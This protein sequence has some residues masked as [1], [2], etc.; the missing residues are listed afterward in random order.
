[1]L[2]DGP[3]RR[4]HSE[5]LGTIALVVAVVS[6]WTA[7][8][9]LFKQNSNAMPYYTYQ[10]LQFRV[11]FQALFFVLAVV[12]SKCL[13]GQPANVTGSAYPKWRLVL[14]GL[15][16][17]AEGY[18]QLVGTTHTNGSLMILMFQLVIPLT[19]LG[20]VV[21]LKRSFTWLQYFSAAVI[22]GGVVLSL[23]SSISVNPQYLAWNF[24]F[25]CSTF[26]A[27]ASGLLKERIFTSK[28]ADVTVLLAYTSS[29]QFLGGWVMGL[30][31]LFLP[32]WGGLQ[33]FW[34]NALQSFQCW[35][36][37]P[38]PPQMCASFALSVLAGG[39]I[40]NY[41]LLMLITHLMASQGAAA[42][43]ISSAIRLPITNICYSLP[44]LM[45]RFTEPATLSNYLSLCII[46]LGMALY[47]YAAWRSRSQQSAL[48][49]V[50]TAV[51]GAVVL[52]SAEETKLLS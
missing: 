38:Q 41:L 23:Y 43:Y 9:V 46:L 51:S 32:P 4:E 42:L 44:F 28:G 34:R 47:Q 52:Q 39:T 24:V 26:F 19:M 21:F 20:S 35:Y 40:T 3:G 36:G 22:M 8:A 50:A 27:A 2:R 14:C 16:D 29:V 11:M 17:C 10:V 15:L 6:T 30:V 33:D 49:P 1:M 12:V 48:T 5:L 37:W 13:F 18:C 45:G 7:N 31:C 25:L